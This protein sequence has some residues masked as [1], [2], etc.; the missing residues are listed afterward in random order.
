MST[1]PV[2][3]KSRIGVVSQ[4]DTLDRALTVADDLAFRG[5]CFGMPAPA[6]RRRAL[7]VLDGFGLRA[8]LA[9]STGHMPTWAC[10]TALTPGTAI[11]GHLALR[12]F[13]REVGNGGPGADPCRGRPERGREAGPG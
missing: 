8:N 3:V 7:E 10:L 12:R 2:A 9:P 13:A 11:L 5:R 1:D 6:A 4:A